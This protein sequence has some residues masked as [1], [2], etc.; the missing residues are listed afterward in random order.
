M[1]TLTVPSNINPLS[2][3]GFMLNI[4]KLPDISYFCQQVNLP[5]ITLGSIDQNTPLSTIGVPGEMLEYA[6]LDVQFLIDEN[7]TNYKAI[8]N[9][10]V[11]LGFPEK[12]SQYTTF[13]N[14]D[15]KS[16]TELG[17]NYS[18]ATLSVLSA[19]NNVVQQISFVDIFPIS[20]DSL[21]FQSTNADVN[22]MIGHASF[23]YS[24]YKFI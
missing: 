23:R 8:Y 12:H 18:D 7:M 9:W 6:Q 15:D 13:I 11:G 1:T 19:T 20:L 17:K 10:M 14:S 4:T 21:V 3:N 22:Y 24:Y 16:R 5:T 2:P